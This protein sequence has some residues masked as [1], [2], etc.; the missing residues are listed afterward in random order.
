MG[1]GVRRSIAAL[2]YLTTRQYKPLCNNHVDIYSYD[3]LRKRINRCGSISKGGGVEAAPDRFFL[4]SGARF[5]DPRRPKQHK[6]PPSPKIEPNNCCVVPDTNECV[7]FCAWGGR[8]P[9][10]KR[11]PQ[12]EDTATIT[13]RRPVDLKA[14]TENTL[15]NIGAHYPETDFK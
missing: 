11:R 14:N 15:G 4:F 8:R 5:L 12:E 3:V 7:C 13:C 6:P 2:L 9:H 10:G 1:G